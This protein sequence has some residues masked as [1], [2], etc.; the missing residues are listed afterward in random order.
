MASRLAQV[1]S[2]D[3]LVLAGQAVQIRVRGS[4]PLN[5]YIS[6]PYM[7]PETAI[8]GLFAQVYLEAMRSAWG[9]ALPTLTDAEIMARAQ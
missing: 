4:G 9:L 7:H 8:S 1:R 3:T 2:G 5:G 6:D